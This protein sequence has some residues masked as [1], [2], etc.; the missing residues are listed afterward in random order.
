MCQHP[1]SVPAGLTAGQN[2]GRGSIVRR[3]L[4]GSGALLCAGLAV[5]AGGYATVAWADTTV[6]TGASC[7]ASALSMP[8]GLTF[9]QL[10]GADP[11]GRY[12]VGTAQDASGQP[13][14]VRWDRGTP[15][16]L[17]TVHYG[18]VAVNR[19]GDLVGAEYDGS[20]N[21]YHAWRYHAG[22]FAPL[23]SLYP[24]RGAYPKAIGPD[25][26]V[27]GTSDD[28]TGNVSQPVAWSPDGTARALVLPVGDNSGGAADIDGDGS[29]VGVTGFDPHDTSPFTMQ[30]TVWNRDGSVRRILPLLGT[31]PLRSGRVVGVAHGA[32]VGIETSGAGTQWLRWP[33]GG[34]QPAVVLAG[35]YPL[36]M[37][38]RG[39]VAFLDSDQRLKLLRGGT[40]QVLSGTEPMTGDGR[41]AAVTNTNQVYGELNRNPVRWDC[42]AA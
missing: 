8:A 17:G 34:G 19:H 18:G 20:I 12:V 33:R 28:P 11:G 4:R 24:G 40:V 26:T 13:H 16:D 42:T 2:T 6:R 22:R 5:T 14:L 3:L 29:I 37:N 9:S 32:V 35:G 38:K 7:P 10:S 15:T 1:M 39:A 30:P 21:S 23:P 36:A 25:G 41:V 27:V 31:D